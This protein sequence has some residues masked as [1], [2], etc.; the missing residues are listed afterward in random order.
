LAHA[1]P[2]FSWERFADIRRELPGLFV[3][4]WEEVALD[5]DK[6][7]LDPH[8]DRYLELD[9]VGILWVLTAR[10]EAKLVGYHFVFVFP[11]L[12]YFSTAWAESDMFWLAPEHRKGLVGYRLLK[13]VR[14]RLKQAGVKKHSFRTKLHIP[15]MERMLARLGYKPI[16]T[17]YAMTLE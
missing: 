7:R 10:V 4:H 11:H 8:W 1:R 16:E 2:E 6:I 9:A 13:I 3:R 15:S 17:V 5:Q 12:H 14:D